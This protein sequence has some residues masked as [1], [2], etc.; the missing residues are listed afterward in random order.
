VAAPLIL[1]IDSQVDLP[2]RLILQH[3]EQF[4]YSKIKPPFG[5]LG[6][7]QNDDA[8]RLKVAAATRTAGLMMLMGGGHGESDIYF[9]QDRLPIYRSAAYDPSEVNGRIIHWTACDTASSLGPHMVRSGASAFFGYLDDFVMDQYWAPY[10][11]D[12][13]AEIDRSLLEGQ[14]AGV[15]HQRA[16][17]RYNYYL[18]RLATADPRRGR[19][20]FEVN[21]NRLRGPLDGA[22][23]GSP[24]ARIR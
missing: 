6:R 21:R 7:L 23:F 16:I 14:T 12:C 3:R 22:Q 9:G 24:H 20:F 13:D 10:L 8:V 2:T 15:A 11:V 17:D 18:G 19:P 5:R 1:T 4:L